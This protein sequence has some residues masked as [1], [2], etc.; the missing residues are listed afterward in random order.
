MGALST[1]RGENP[2]WHY[3][4][5]IHHES[6]HR[7]STSNTATG[8]VRRWREIR[9]SASPVRSL[10]RTTDKK[11]SKEDLLPPLTG[12]RALLEKTLSVSPG[13]GAG[14]KFPPLDA[15]LSPLISLLPQSEKNATPLAST[16]DRIPVLPTTHAEFGD[17]RW[18]T[19]MCTVVPPSVVLC[20]TTQ[21][22][23][24]E[25]LT[26]LDAAISRGENYVPV[27]QRLYALSANAGMTELLEASNRIAVSQYFRN[28]DER[29]YMNHV[30]NTNYWQEVQD[31]PAFAPIATSSPAIS[32]G[33]LPQYIDHLAA[34]VD[35]GYG[36]IV[37]QAADFYSTDG[38]SVAI[39]E[40]EGGSPSPRAQSTRNG[41]S[42]E[43]NIQPLP[44]NNFSTHFQA[45]TNRL[46]TVSPTHLVPTQAEQ[47]RF[48]EKYV[49]T[50]Q[51]ISS[52]T[53]IAD[54]AHHDTSSQTPSILDMEN[55][56]LAATGRETISAL[57]YTTPEQYEDF[58]ARILSKRTALSE[59]HHAI[60]PH[61]PRSLP[62]IH[63]QPRTDFEKVRTMSSPCIRKAQQDQA[64]APTPAIK[65]K[66]KLKLSQPKSDHQG[67][68][69]SRKGSSTADPTATRAQ[70]PSHQAKDQHQPITSDHDAKTSKPSPFPFPITEASE[71]RDQQS[72]EISAPEHTAHANANGNDNPHPNAPP[73]RSLRQNPTPSRKR[74]YSEFE[75]AQRPRRVSFCGGRAGTGAGAGPGAGRASVRG[76]GHG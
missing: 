21:E 63:D 16:Q 19:E 26:A 44:S 42:P 27:Q 48:L 28:L 22:D 13:F 39:S 67:E 3:R 59:A 71:E 65:I 2:P 32:T 4:T 18:K 50:L 72:T 33:Q 49:P 37:G 24:L 57:Q 35:P 55:L 73:S 14:E 20:D 12:A 10:H 9:R 64:Q 23:D 69:R 5:P 38:T 1:V 60:L 41:K 25:D 46:D 17:P 15:R 31:D 75:Q 7:T 56:Y 66:I 76:Q 51:F 45:P 29:L 68:R 54:E 40:S 52:D 61:K 62:N 36:F 47:H 34:E 70:E 53:A 8:P 6:T 43:Q 74:L 11:S 58:A 30:S